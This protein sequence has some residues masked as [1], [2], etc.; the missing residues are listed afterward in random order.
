[1]YVSLHSFADA[2][3]SLS[4]NLTIDEGQAD[5]IMITTNSTFEASVIVEVDIAGG[6]GKCNLQLLYAVHIEDLGV[7]LRTDQVQHSASIHP[8]H[9]GYW[10]TANIWCINQFS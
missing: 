4:G 3:F 10:W 1:M 7:S 6:S 5:S 2:V 9:R 8:T